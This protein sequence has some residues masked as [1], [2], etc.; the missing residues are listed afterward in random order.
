MEAEKVEDGMRAVV[1]QGQQLV[2][3]EKLGNRVLKVEA[4]GVGKL[5]V[6]SFDAEMPCADEPWWYL[7]TVT[8]IICNLNVFDIACSGYC[9][10]QDETSNQGVQFHFLLFDLPNVLFRATCEQ[11]NG[12]SQK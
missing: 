7:Q 8:A 5:S 1:I 11:T 9:N 4:P 6:P 3:M 10:P 2:E 12:V